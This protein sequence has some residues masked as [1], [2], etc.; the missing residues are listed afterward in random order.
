VLTTV[1]RKEVHLSLVS[2]M[3]AECQSLGF[4]EV[5]MDL[6]VGLP[7]ETINGI[8]AGFRAAVQSGANV[9][10]VYVYRHR[11]IKD[12]D[13]IDYNNAYVPSVLRALRQSAREVGWIDTVCD[14]NPEYQFFTTQKHLDSYALN[15]YQTRYDP[16][17]LNSV[18][19]MGH[20]AFSFIGDFFRSEC[21]DETFSF[22]PA[23]PT[24]AYDLLP[25]GHRCRIYVI[26]Q[27]Y[28]EGSV[29][30]AD[31]EQRFGNTFFDAFDKELALL[32]ALG[33]IQ[34]ATRQFSLK[35]NDRLDFAALTKFF[36]DQDLL[37]SF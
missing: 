17:R 19:G 29:D 11:A 2:E 18:L 27:L 33:A 30:L 5:N 26:E 10:T 24:N 32:D 6:M 31:Y 9:V 13:L 35:A 21:R 22:N 20:T 7:Q 14:D 25:Y 3:I 28:R 23:S 34:S 36:W 37:N 12:V 15:A 4:S 16:A 8:C 1:N